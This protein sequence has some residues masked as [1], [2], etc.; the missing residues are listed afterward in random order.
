MAFSFD[1]S[2][3][4]L[5][6]GTRRIAIEQIDRALDQIDRPSLLQGEAVHEIRKSVKK[7]RALLRL[8]RP[9]LAEHRALDALLRDA[10]R[11]VAALRDAAVLLHTLDALA[12]DGL[13]TIR[14]AFTQAPPRAR[15][16]AD[17]A[18]AA[19][20]ADLATARGQ[21]K[22]LALQGAEADVLQAGLIL[23]LHQAQTTLHVALRDTAPEAVHNFRK[24]VK[25]HLY[26][27]RLLT[28]LWPVMMGPHAEAAE[29]LAETLG[30]MNDIAV[31]RDALTGLDLPAGER[32]DA[33][34]LARVRH[35]RL[36]LVALPLATRLF[37]GRPQDVAE[38]WYAW[39][40]IWRAEA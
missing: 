23:T 28:P 32:A 16:A 29:E 40:A 2:D 26:H 22:A 10:A 36:S 27:A 5:A 39:W 1:L 8:V 14:A 17:E 34:V 35:D 24:R 31:F 4:T 12:P 15:D 13:P 30:L 37:A 20:R 18:L 21:I 3:R 9:G 7:L 19:C 38:R 11:R 33:E 6:R 25:D